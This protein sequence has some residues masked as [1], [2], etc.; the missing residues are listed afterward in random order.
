MTSCNWKL[1]LFIGIEKETKPFQHFFN[2]ALC[3]RGH[4][5]RSFLTN[6]SLQLLLIGILFHANHGTHS[7]IFTKY[8]S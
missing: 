6:T 2:L 8:F 1:D 7:A 4:V 3:F 5:L